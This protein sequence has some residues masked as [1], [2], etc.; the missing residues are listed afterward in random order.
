V[1][2]SLQEMVVGFSACKWMIR[3]SLSLKLLLLITMFSLSYA[4]SDEISDDGEFE[5]SAAS[6]PAP[7]PT[8][9]RRNAN[10]DIECKKKVR[11]TCCKLS[12][13]AHI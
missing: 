7:P 1:I 9:G 13:E 11:Y 6:I 10:F 8:S 4:D 5:S 3:Q 12:K 2:S